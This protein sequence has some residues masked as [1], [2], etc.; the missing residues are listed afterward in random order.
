M[1][2]DRRSEERR[3]Q[4]RGRE[5]GKRKSLNTEDTEDAESAEKTKTGRAEARRYR[6]RPYMKITAGR[7]GR[8]MLRPYKKKQECGAKRLA[9]RKRRGGCAGGLRGCH[10]WRRAG[11]CRSRER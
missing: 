2:L 5:P 8:S 11:S 6:S 10:W 9:L 7:F 3:C 4:A 1:D